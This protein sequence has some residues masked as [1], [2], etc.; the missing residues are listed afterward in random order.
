VLV[1]LFQA[2]RIV[3]GTLC[4]TR[5]RMS[6]T[7]NRVA[8]L[9]LVDAIVTD[10]ASQSASPVAALDVSL[11]QVFLIIPDDQ[12][13]PG[14]R[15]W[16]RRRRVEIAVGGFA[17]LGELHGPAAADPIANLH[18]RGAFVPLTDATIMVAASGAGLAA[19]PVVIVNTA[20][21]TSMR[22]AGHDHTLRPIGRP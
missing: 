11:D 19:T 22:D 21:A 4:G 10:L 7:V 15:I 13:P 2:D 6:D 9:R 14:R 12:P 8:G 1:H 5:G 16:T 18:R 3:A 20:A 17:V